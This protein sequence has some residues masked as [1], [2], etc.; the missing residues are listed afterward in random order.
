MFGFTEDEVV[1]YSRHIILPEVGGKGQKRLGESNVLVVGAGGLGSPAALYLAAAGV[2]LIGLVD[3]DVVDLSNL[4]RQILHNT[5]D[6][7]RPK[8]DSARDT[9]ESLNPLV[10][11]KTYHTLL[12]ADNVLDIINDEDYDVVVDGVDNFPARYL[13]NDAC[14]LSNKPLVEAGILRFNGMAMTILPGRGP[15]YR[16][17][18]PEPPPE[19]TIP[20]CA[21]AGVIGSLA[22]TIGVIQATEA[23]KLVLGIGKP[24]VGRV[25]T[26]DALAGSFQTLEWERDPGCAVCGENPTITD[27]VEYELACDIRGA[28]VDDGRV[29]EGHA[30]TAG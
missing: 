30:R 13:L 19:G 20:S 10:R 21:Q 8:V 17:V 4:Q 1:R 23:I 7:G 24:L 15:C 9:L 28:A 22:G 12:S 6:L 11:V 26:Y 16:C 14:V 29:V 2:G 18:F 27:L 3:S 5:L 25:L